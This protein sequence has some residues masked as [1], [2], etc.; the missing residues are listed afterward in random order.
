MLGTVPHVP[1]QPQA[2]S[3]ETCSFWCLHADWV[4]KYPGKKLPFFQE[5]RKKHPE[6]LVHIAHPATISQARGRSMIAQQ[7]DGASEQ[8][9]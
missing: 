6:A 5:L 9:D 7:L 8:N 4:R 1:P 3:T 2:D